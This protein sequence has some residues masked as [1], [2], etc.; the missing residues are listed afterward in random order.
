MAATLDPHKV[1]KIKKAAPNRSGFLSC[2]RGRGRTS[3]RQLAITQSSV[4]DPGR[5][6]LSG[7]ML[8]LSRYPHPR[9]KRARLPNISSPHNR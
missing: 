5:L 8:R 3:R 6:L 1:C 4:V 7:S 2:C 9:D